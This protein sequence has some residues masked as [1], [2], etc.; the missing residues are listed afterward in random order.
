MDY[1]LQWW[2]T[3]SGRY[4]AVGAVLGDRREW[5][6]LAYFY[7]A[8]GTAWIDYT[9]HHGAGK[10]LTYA[11]ASAGGNVRA[12]RGLLERTISGLTNAG[13]FCRCVHVQPALTGLGRLWGQLA[14]GQRM[15]IF[16]GRPD[17]AV[18]TAM[19]RCSRWTLVGKSDHPH[20]VFSAALVP[21]RRLMPVSF[22]PPMAISTG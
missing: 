19:A 12:G 14:P 18:C 11:P 16:M 10:E 2:N 8:N 20:V 21:A 5:A 6:P 1:V 4:Y 3:A 15:A 7:G 9:P 17:S 13:T 22:R